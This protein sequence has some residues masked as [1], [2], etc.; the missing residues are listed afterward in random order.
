MLKTFFINVLKLLVAGALIAWL[1][2]SDKLDFKLITQLKHHPQSVLLAILLSLINLTLISIRWRRILS[3]RSTYPL[4]LMGL[5]NVNWI[6]QFF[7]SVLPGSFSGD[8]IKLLYVQNLNPELSKKFVLASVLIDRVIGL[9]GLILLVGLSSLFFSS[10]ILGNS[11]DMKPLL[12]INY[13]LAVSVLVGLT[14][15]FFFHG[16]VRIILQKLQA[17][18]WRHLFEKII[19]FWDD[20][21]GIKSYIVKAIVM[22]ILIQ[23]IGV[24]I[25]WSLIHPFIQGQMDFREALAFIPIGFMTLALPVAPSGLGVGHAIFQKLFQLSGIENGA[26]LFNI[27]FFVMLSVNLAGVVPWLLLRGSNLEDKNP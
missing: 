4:P 12:L 9:F 7:S 25:F 16:F 21:T 11:P 19:T 5:I 2:S 10:H 17:F 20:L 13:A 6:G 8:L 26:S 3:A 24:L 23:F 1:I 27:Y 18:G 22:S 14:F 15:F